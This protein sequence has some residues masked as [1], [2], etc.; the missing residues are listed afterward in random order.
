MSEI[1]WPALE[2]S[3]LGLELHRGEVERK[4][5]FREQSLR[6][7]PDRFVQGFGALL[8]EGEREAI[9]LKVTQVSQAINALF[10]ESV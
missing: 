9:L 4:K 2:P 5:A 3:A 10:H 7:H 8:H 6:W 1:P